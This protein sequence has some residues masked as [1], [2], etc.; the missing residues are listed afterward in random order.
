MNETL[1][2]A[3]SKKAKKRT[4]GHIRK[5][6]E[7][8]YIVYSVAGRKKEEVGGTTA[9]QA[10]RLLT[11]RLFE[12]DRGFVRN[13]KPMTFREFIEVWRTDHVATQ[14]LK[15]ATIRGYDSVI[16]RH[17]L[18]AFGNQ[19]MDR[20]TAEHI[21]R[22]FKEKQ[23]A[24][25]E[26][27]SRSLSKKTLINTLRLLNSIFNFA[28]VIELLVKN[29]CKAI[30][31]PRAPKREMDF[32]RPEEVRAFLGAFTDEEMRC[33]FTTAVMTGMRRGEILGLQWDDVDF[34]GNVIRVRR[35]ISNGEIQLPKTE[36]SRRAV[37][38]GPTL[39]KTL[40][41]HKLRTGTRSSFVFT[42]KNGTLA[43]SGQP[44]EARLRAD[45]SRGGDRAAHPL[46]RPSAHLRIDPDQRGCEP[47]V[48]QRAARSRIDHDHP[49]PLLAPDRRAPR[50]HG[51]EVREVAAGGSGS[52]LNSSGA[53]LRNR[54]D[55]QH[56]GT[57][58]GDRGRIP[59]AARAAPIHQRCG[60]RTCHFEVRGGS[61]SK[62][63]RF[64][65][66]DACAV[67]T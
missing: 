44:G 37:Q 10:K 32:L 46:S 24:T 58:H 36:K 21:R 55:R 48:R 60:W 54:E 42:T 8:Y 17:L 26:K 1:K 18:P 20:I 61:I 65:S 63:T 28:M 12:A 39:L 22:F 35:S 15:P 38:V 19:R 67:R 16:E 5:R 3:P 23:E 29:P 14:E 49:R 53:S 4:R 9:E 6:G 40:R 25:S 33:L 57:P 7:K 31:L 66:G 11:Q 59:R 2:S 45:D 43:R 52:G 64:R 47:E 51:V 13:A 62:R 27:T 34:K 41:A 30:K 50:R 56:R